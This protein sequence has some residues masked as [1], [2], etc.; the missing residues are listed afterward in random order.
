MFPQWS[1]TD[2][3]AQRSKAGS[4]NLTEWTNI[5][6]KSCKGSECLYFNG[7]TAFGEVT[8]NASTDV[9]AQPLGI[10]VNVLFAESQN[11]MLLF[12][13][14]G[15]GSEDCQYHMT[16][17][18][19]MENAYVGLE[20]FAVENYTDDNFIFADIWYDIGLW[21]DKDQLNVY[22]NGVKVSDDAEYDG[23]LT[24]TPKEYIGHE[25]EWYCYLE[26]LI[27]NVS[28]YGAGALLPEVLEHRRRICRLN[29]IKVR[30]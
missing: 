4:K 13:R 7:K 25:T 8:D 9:L 30:V 15:E 10:F 26:G 12:I 1:D 28:I 21:W 2:L 23:A 6:R 18:S 14:T 5:V 29:D 11:D 19:D 16:H 17:G 20:Q 22:I 3:N 24:S 27:F